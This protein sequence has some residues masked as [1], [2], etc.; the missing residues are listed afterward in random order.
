MIKYYKEF[1]NEIKK[2]KEYYTTNKSKTELSNI[3]ISVINSISIIEQRIS[4]KYTIYLK[5]IDLINQEIQI[6]NIDNYNYRIKG[7][8]HVN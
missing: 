4:E 2:I 6:K 7:T 1:I 8:T 5:D 3:G